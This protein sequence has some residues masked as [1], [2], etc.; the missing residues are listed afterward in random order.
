MIGVT[1]PTVE[2]SA[3]GVPTIGHMDIVDPKFPCG[4]TD[5]DFDV[6]SDG[7]KEDLQK[8]SGDSHHVT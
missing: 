3:A 4:D 7:R 1:G 2:Q 5:Y 8:T 6:P